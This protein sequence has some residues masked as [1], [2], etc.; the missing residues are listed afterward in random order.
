M[1]FNDHWELEGRHAFLSPSQHYWLNYTPEK[2]ETT[3]LNA[4]AR[5]RGTKLHQLAS[6]CI[7]MGVKLARNKNTLNQFVNDAIGFK[8]ESEQPL[9]YSEYCFGTADAIS[10]KKNVLRIF[11]L[12]T[13]ALPAS[14]NQL[15]V[16][17]AL[18]CLEYSIRPADIE[19]IELR[20]YQSNEVLLEEGDPDEIQSI[21]DLI[22]DFDHQLN[23]LDQD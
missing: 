2:L 5:E 18:F 10:F 13:G 22:V 16:Y 7:K 9:Y 6:D 12:K 4:K 1:L 21:M 11:D 3:F 19:H 14:M 23:L 8:M 15:K 17:A 20:I